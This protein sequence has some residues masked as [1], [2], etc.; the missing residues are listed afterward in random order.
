MKWGGRYGVLILCIQLRSNNHEI[1]MRVQI[2]EWR[3]LDNTVWNIHITKGKCYPSVDLQHSLL[4]WTYHQ[5]QRQQHHKQLICSSKSSCHHYKGVT[6]LVIT[7]FS[8]EIF[9]NREFLLGHLFGSCFA[10][11]KEFCK[12]AILSCIQYPLS[13]TDDGCE[14][15][16]SAITTSPSIGGF[17]CNYAPTNACS[18]SDADGNCCCNTV[19]SHIFY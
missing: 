19:S 6:F 12:N 15:C 7:K 11:Y 17:T 9:W 16:T 4:W 18:T 13:S 2:W 5:M 1:M 14:Y 3:F 8:S 10:V